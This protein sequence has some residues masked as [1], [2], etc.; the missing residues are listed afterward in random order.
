M[1][2]PVVDRFKMIDLAHQERERSPETHCAGNLAR[3]LL[4]EKAS[5]TTTGELVDGGENAIAG[6]GRLQRSCKADQAP[7]DGHVRPESL[8]SGVC[9]DDLIRTRAQGVRRP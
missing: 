4:L 8:A 9:R 3:E 2:V 6:D 5:I 1:S 7:H